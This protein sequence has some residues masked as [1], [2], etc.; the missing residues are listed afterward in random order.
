[1]QMIERN[2]RIVKMREAGAKYKTIAREFGISVERV[3]QIYKAHKRY[4][5]IDSDE[6]FNALCEAA[7]KRGYGVPLA[8]R[9]YHCLTRH[10]ANSV[11]GIDEITDDE[12]LGLRGFG[13][14]TLEIV[15]TAQGWADGSLNSRDGIHDRRHRGRDGACN[16]DGGKG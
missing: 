12:L 13:A 9:A 2:M 1:M 10:G 3:R 6:L 15:R 5:V 16:S 14:K 4:S 7:E 11:D 8:V